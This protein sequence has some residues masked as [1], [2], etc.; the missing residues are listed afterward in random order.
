MIKLTKKSSIV[1]WQGFSPVKVNTKNN[2]VPFELI[3]TLFF[4]AQPST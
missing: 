3:L 4:A 2:L 1:F